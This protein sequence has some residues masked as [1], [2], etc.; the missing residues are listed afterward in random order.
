MGRINFGLQMEKKG[1]GPVG[2]LLVIVSEATSED[3]H[4]AATTGNDHRV[5]SSSLGQRTGSLAYWCPQDTSRRVGEE[6]AERCCLCSV[7]VEYQKK[8]KK[9]QS[10]II[11]PKTTSEHPQGAAPICGT[12]G[13]GV[14]ATG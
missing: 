5:Y 9:A 11:V 3:P 4:G 10:F 13:L 14:N 7:T 8:E 2:I 6:P 12:P 1:I